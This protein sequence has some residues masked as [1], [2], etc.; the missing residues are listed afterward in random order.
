M[1]VR[2]TCV[3]VACLVL[4]PAVSPAAAEQES[5]RSLLLFGPGAKNADGIEAAGYARERLHK[6]ER[7]QERVAVTG[8]P[9]PTDQPY[10][11]TG[12]GRASWC[13]AGGAVQGNL[14][15][16]VDRARRAMDVLESDKVIDLV[17]EFVANSPCLAE[18]AEPQVLA[19]LILLRGLARH[20][21]GDV[22]G[23]Q[24]DFAHAAGIYPNLS[25]DVGYPP[26]PQQTYLVAREAIAKAETVAFG[27]STS[28]VQPVVVYV[29]G[30]QIPP[31]EMVELPPV[32]HLVQIKGTSDVTSLSLSLSDGDS[33]VLVDRV[34]ATAAVMGGPSSELSGTASRTI[35]DALAAQ[36]NAEQ[37]VVVDTRYRKED[38][39]PLVYRYHLTDREFEDLTAIKIFRVYLPRHA[40]HVRVAVGGSLQWETEAADNIEGHLALRP[41]GEVEFR[42]GPNFAPGGGLDL[43][44]H[45]VTDL[46]TGE[47]RWAVTPQ[48]RVC[49][50]SRFRPRF[51]HPYLGINVLAR[52]DQN[53]GRGVVFGVAMVGNIDIVL[54][55][56]PG[57]FLRIGGSLG[58]IHEN[59]FVE[60]GAKVGIRL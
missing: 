23:A 33:A 60:G 40:D 16:M 35:L 11:V 50:G 26:D 32:P 39:E 36:W 12:E 54:P 41:S 9:F 51:V 49:L 53:L 30:V 56:L 31:F 58:N 27:Y 3:L 37:V 47:S 15:H 38:K 21:D 7:P 22:D 59:L 18:V 29:D 4:A 46:T 44:A 8:I 6:K 20:V 19:Q 55:R 2:F 34:G 28:L 13:P 10:W 24:A 42:V 17:D 1:S 43:I 57:W 52:F 48:L 14:A 5:V 25:W 45:R